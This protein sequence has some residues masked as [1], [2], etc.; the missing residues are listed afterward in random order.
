M[1]N[2]PSKAAFGVDMAY[3]TFDAA[4]GLQDVEGNFRLGDK[5]KQFQNTP[6]GVR[7][8]LKWC[9][10]QLKKVKLTKAQIIVE[11]T[12][13]YH[14]LLVTKAYGADASLSVCL[15]GSKNARFFR[16]SKNKYS[17]TDRLDA[18]SLSEFGCERKHKPWKP[19]SKNLLEI[20][21]LLRYRASLITKKNMETNQQHAH[22]VAVV[23]NK[24]L[25]SAVKANLKHLSKQIVKIEAEV[26]KLWRE[27][28]DLYKR[29]HRIAET[30]PGVRWLTVLI[31]ITETNGFS[32]ITSGKQLASYAGL[33]VI[34]NQSG[35]T[36]GKTRIS[37]KGNTHLR[38]SLYMSATCLNRKSIRGEIA[39]FGRR[40]A[41]RN[42]KCKKKATVAM[43]R[44]QLL[45]IRTLYLSGEDYDPKYEANKK[46]SS[47]QERQEDD[48]RCSQQQEEKKGSPSKSVPRLHEVDHFKA[49]PQET[50]LE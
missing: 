45:L 36:A 49:S 43:M 28:E 48:S 6:V 19:G 50:K 4:F 11:A 35:N 40:I 46:V 17:K 16:L 39:A 5:T 37:K 13:V 34:E 47:N 32:E 25:N 31:V 7:K 21:A 22:N 42:P 14:E 33:D 1:L 26:K 15:V 12:G 41:K 29:T 10:Q 20:K 2:D 44:K 30:M 9:R 3:K 18:R 38:K 27:D 24:V 8:F 23:S